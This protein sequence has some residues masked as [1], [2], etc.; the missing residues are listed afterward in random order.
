MEIVLLIIENI[1]TALVLLIMGEILSIRI[2]NEIKK[3]NLIYIPEDYIRLFSHI[4]II[5]AYIFYRIILNF[6]I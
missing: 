4:I 1:F 6:L 5:S 3:D 2:M